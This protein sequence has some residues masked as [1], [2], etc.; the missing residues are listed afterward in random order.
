M[1]KAISLS[2][3]TKA[4]IEKA[5]D[6]RAEKALLEINLGVLHQSM[7][8]NHPQV[9]RLRTQIGEYT[10]QLRRME[11]GGK[12]EDFLPP[13][14]RVPSLALELARLTRNLKVEEE[15]FELLTQQYEQVKIQEKRDTP[16]VQV[17]DEAIPPTQKSK[18]KRTVLVGL[19]GLLSLFVG[20]FLAFGLEYME[21]VSSSEDSQKISRI[22][23]LLR[24]DYLRLR[25]KL[26][27]KRKEG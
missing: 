13:F 6:L 20:V 5:A 3:Q 1:H 22:S 10:R 18:P 25:D 14:S 2:D 11:F 12:G 26:T 24:E 4:A 23:F 16:T 17:L 21:R 27:R 19:A 8:G 9:Q 7:G 15:I